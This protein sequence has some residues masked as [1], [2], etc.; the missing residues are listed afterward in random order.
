MGGSR[1]SRQNTTNN[2][3]KSTVFTNTGG[4]TSYNLSESSGNSIHIESLD[5]RT[6]QD[7]IDGNR[8]AIEAGFDY[9]E[10]VAGDAFSYGDNVNKRA[11]D[12]LES[13]SGDLIALAQSGTEDALQSNLDVIR[14][15][16]GSIKQI[17]RNAA[18]QV[19]RSLKVASSSMQ[20]DSAETLQAMFKYSAI[21]AAVIA[22]VAMM[23][24]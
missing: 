17:S 22:G 18:D 8:R 21:A 13:N 20:S 19:D 5:A 15:S 11:F 16:F 24:K 7:A 23:R 1:S 14:E 9:G 10:A 3:Q 12:F 6:A 4:G 2:T